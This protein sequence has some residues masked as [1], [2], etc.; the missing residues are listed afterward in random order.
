MVVLLPRLPGPAADALF[1]Q[2]M[3]DGFGETFVFS[4]RDLPEAARFAATG[5]ARATSKQLSDLRTRILEIARRN[6]FSNRGRRFGLA[7]FDAEMAGSL[8]EDLLF[9]TGEALRDDVWAFVGL[10]LAPDVVHW[11]FGTSRERYLGG[12]RNTFQRL[13]MRGHAL[14]RGAD[15]QNRWQLLKELTEDAFVQI[16]ERPSLGGDSELAKAIAEAWVR[17]SE[18]YGK[19]AME[20]IMRRAALQIRIWNEVRSLADLPS[21][22]LAGILND[23][24]GLPAALGSTAN[25]SFKSTGT[26]EGHKKKLP[27]P[28]ND[29]AHPSQTQDHDQSDDRPACSV[30]MA[31]VRVLGE[32]RRRSWVSPKS[33]AALNVIAQ[34]HRRLNSRE[35]NSLNHLL[36]RMRSVGLLRKET[37]QLTEALMAERSPRP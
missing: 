16:M 30:P 7:Q 14:D 5:G 12:V 13:W 24:F 32:A 29:M 26:E 4:P 1:A 37:S 6:G 25:A 17:A 15:H 35:R 10:S 9:A 23:A 34:G 21:D 22:Q 31:A 19:S 28:T 8:A 2:R 11:R 18:H 20:P 3:A 36:S 33:L 27:E